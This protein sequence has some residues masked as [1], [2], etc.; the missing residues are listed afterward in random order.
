VKVGGKSYESIWLDKDD[1]ALVGVIDQRK[2]PYRFEILMLSSVEDVYNA[3]SNMTVRGA[4]LIGVAGAFGIYLATLEMTSKTRERDHILNAA[5]FLSS[6]RPTAVNLDWAINLQL[7]R[8]EGAKSREA[9]IRISRDTALEICSVEVENCKGIGEAGL[10][11]IEDISKRKNG[12]TVNILTHCNAGWLA[13]VDYGTAT[14]PIYRAHDKGLDV[15]VWVD[16]TRPRNQGARLTA[17]ELGEHGVPHTLITDNAGGHLMQKGEVDIVIV[18]CD[19]ASSS[20]DVAN[21]IGTYIKALAANDNNIP[22]YS[23]LPSS[24]IDRKIKDGLKEIEIEER[25]GKEVTH[26]EGLYK[27]EIVEIELC[28]PG[29]KAANYG[30]DVT[31]SRLISGLITE[32]GIVEA[33]EKGIISLFTK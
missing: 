8:L 23:A 20:G 27:N 25:D 2:L 21:K 14:A 32:K 4:P 15:H 33:S 6:S 22:F 24:T 17:F 16:E 18:G 1:N 30:F 28:P 26:I 7:E 29:T 10:P 3:I 12:S 9:L 13:C 11:L 31:P 19:R 5:K